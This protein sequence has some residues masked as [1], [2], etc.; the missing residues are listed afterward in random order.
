MAFFT[1]FT[2]IT[3]CQFYC[4]TSP[5]L[6]TKNKELWNERKEVFCIHG[7]YIALRR[8]IAKEAENHIM[9]RNAFL[10]T[11]VGINNPF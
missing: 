5:L 10:D 4:I 8:Y 11:D 2:C 7:C 9:D 3:L 6:F 1:P